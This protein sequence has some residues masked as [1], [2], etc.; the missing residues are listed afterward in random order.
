MNEN[1][2]LLKY[3]VRFFTQHVIDAAIDKT[4]TSDITGCTHAYVCK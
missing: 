3:C 1:N 4:V 2:D